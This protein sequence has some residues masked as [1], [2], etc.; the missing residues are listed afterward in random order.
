M[1]D[2]SKERLRSEQILAYSRK[3]KMLVAPP[4]APKIVPPP[5]PP[6]IH[7]LPL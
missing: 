5:P 4:L 7:D 6:P 1:D 2:A 3:G